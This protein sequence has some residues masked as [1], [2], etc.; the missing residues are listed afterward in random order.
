MGGGCCRW[1]LSTRSTSSRP[2]TPTSSRS[3]PSRSSAT[4][5]CVAQCAGTCTITAT[6]EL[7][8]RHTIASSAARYPAASA[9]ENKLRSLPLEHGDA[10][11]LLSSSSSSSD[12][13]DD[14][15]EAEDEDD[16]E[17]STP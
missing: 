10:R 14:E 6:S 1:C 11:Q 5:T 16:D 15:D 12:E 9:L 7:P 4:H 8:L 2:T 17:G 13:E 3:S